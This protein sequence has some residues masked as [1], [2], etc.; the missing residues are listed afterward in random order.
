MASW[1]LPGRAPSP[2]AV[3]KH[4]IIAAVSEASAYSIP[5]QNC[6]TVCHPDVIKEQSW[7]KTLPLR[8]VMNPRQCN[9]PFSEQQLK[10]ALPLAYHTHLGEATN[11]EEFHKGQL[12]R[13]SISWDT[14]PVQAITFSWILAVFCSHGTRQ[15]FSQVIPKP[16]MTYCCVHQVRQST[17]ACQIHHFNGW[18]KFTVPRK[19]E[20]TTGNSSYTGDHSFKRLPYDSQWLVQQHLGNC[21]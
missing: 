13:A 21:P 19:E 5:S 7:F 16:Q 6:C 18:R 8:V 14:V 12:Y 2:S 9:G 15:A 4:S 20:K 11:K 3:Q 10:A 17:Q 1:S